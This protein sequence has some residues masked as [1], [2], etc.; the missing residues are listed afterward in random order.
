CG[1]QRVPQA[2]QLQR[3]QQALRQQLEHSAGLQPER[4]MP[5]LTGPE[6]GYR[7]RTRLSV[8]EGPRSGR[9]QVGYR[10]RASSELVEVSRCPVLNPRREGG[11]RDLFEHMHP[12]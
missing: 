12:L 10:Q 5:A 11:V 4:W 8:R 7:Q 3:K 9:L 2:T 1:L 6:Y